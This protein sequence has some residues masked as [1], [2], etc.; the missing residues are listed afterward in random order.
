MAHLGIEIP[1]PMRAPSRAQAF[2]ASA[3]WLL[4]SLPF[5]YLAS[6]YW[7]WPAGLFTQWRGWV[8]SLVALACLL[9][10]TVVPPRYRVAI[11]GTKVIAWGRLS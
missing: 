7:S 9:A 11:V 3:I 1:P 2:V 4:A 5:F 8:F 10:A 6:L